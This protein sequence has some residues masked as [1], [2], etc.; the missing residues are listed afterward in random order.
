MVSAGIGEDHL[1]FAKRV[2]GRFCGSA[3]PQTTEPAEPQTT[4][5]AEPQTAEP[6]GK[7]YCCTIPSVFTTQIRPLESL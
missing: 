3:E 7:G 5:P 4:E 1:F 2:W 6:S